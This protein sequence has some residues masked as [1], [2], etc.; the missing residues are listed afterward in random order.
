MLAEDSRCGFR[1]HITKKKDQPGSQ[2]RTMGESYSQQAVHECAE[3][4]GCRRAQRQ[5]FV[6]GPA[7]WTAGATRVLSRLP[8]A[9]DSL[10]P[11][12]PPHRALVSPRDPD[13]S[14]LDAPGWWSDDEVAVMLPSIEERE[15]RT[16]QKKLRRYSLDDTD[17]MALTHITEEDEAMA[18]AVAGESGRT[19]VP[20]PVAR[21]VL[22]PGVLRQRVLC[23]KKSAKTTFGI[24]FSAEYAQLA[25]GDEGARLSKQLGEEGEWALFFIE[26]VDPSHASGAEPTG[27]E[28]LFE[29]IACANLGRI[30]N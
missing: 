25:N 8:G 27:M 10:P 29:A 14:H 5:I 2:V 3:G 30:Q 15:E 6:A 22:D 1:S 21:V 16:L 23:S 9:G 13:L 20:D 28:I 12:F 26:L 7:S 11:R 18:E 17:M 4:G 24:W 19:R